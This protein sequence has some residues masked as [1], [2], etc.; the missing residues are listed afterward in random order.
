MC[1]S[2]Q[3][4]FACLVIPAFNPAFALVGLLE[5]IVS[6][7]RG[8]IVVV[9]D[10][11]FDAQAPAIFSRVSELGCTVIPHE[12]N[13]GKGAALKTAFSWILGTMD[14]PCLG[15]VTADADGQHELDDIL[16]VR[17]ALAE[18]PSKLVL[19][20]RDF[21]SGG[22][23]ARSRIGNRVMAGAMRLFFGVRL[24][25]TQTGLRGIPYELLPR[26]LDVSG[27]AYEYETNML[28]EA[29]RARVDIVE[30][31]IRTV[32]ENGNE[33]SSFNPFLDSLRIAAV[34]IKYAI[35]SA[36]SSV[37]DLLA[38]SLLNVVFSNLGFGL[39]S[40]AV[41]TCVARVISGVVNFAVNR[42]LVFRCGDGRA[43]LRYAT[44]WVSCMCASAF[45]VTL[46]NMAASV[47][48]TLII[49]IVVD[50]ALFFANYRIQEAWV[51]VDGERG[52]MRGISNG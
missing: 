38:F 16:A 25:D 23:P 2:S 33:T 28:V 36:A 45:F 4:P 51:F 20:S 15:V 9:D 48:P 10:G 27:D 42:R 7:W 1:E 35:S 49:K 30:V 3:D 19:G 41:A 46:L 39:L 29:H 8:P 47:V 18:D 52:K 24:A 17:D 31:P 43:A 13:R 11:S 34:F 5:R 32:Y 26:L 6:L 21:S 22:A 37:V 40:I 12:R 50:V 44:L 14:E